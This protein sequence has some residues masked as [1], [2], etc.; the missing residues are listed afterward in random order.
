MCYPARAC[1]RREIS[2]SSECR[3]SSYNACRLSATR[4]PVSTARASERVQ[5]YTHTLYIILQEGRKR[6]SMYMCVRATRCFISES[7]AAISRRTFRTPRGHPRTR[8]VRINQPRPRAR[9]L[10][11][12]KLL[13]SP[14]ETLYT[15]DSRRRRGL[16]FAAQTFFPSRERVVHRTGGTERL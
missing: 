7:H 9:V 6:E 12:I 15:P 11:L 5:R 1:G 13:Y 14:R 3:L 2:S 8:L 16:D 4:E 10:I